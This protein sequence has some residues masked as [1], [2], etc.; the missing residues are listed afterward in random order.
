MKKTSEIL[1]EAIRLLRKWEWDYES[2]CP[3]CFGHFSGGHRPY[4]KLASVL[5]A[6]AESEAEGD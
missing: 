4:C 2:V 3:Q 1:C 5:A 6:A